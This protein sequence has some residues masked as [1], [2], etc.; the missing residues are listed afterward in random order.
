MRGLFCALPGSKFQFWQSQE[1]VRSGAD[2]VLEIIQ[3]DPIVLR[4]HTTVRKMLLQKKKRVH[5]GT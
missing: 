1:G 3:T 5:T 2:S 4:L